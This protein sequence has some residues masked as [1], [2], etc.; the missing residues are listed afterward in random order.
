MSAINY[1]TK[2]LKRDNPSPEVKALVLGELE[3]MPV[4]GKETGR[5]INRNDNII[6]KDKPK[7][8][9]GTSPTWAGRLS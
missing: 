7:K 8:E 6:S 3:S 2:R 4:K 9:Q 5:G 1:L